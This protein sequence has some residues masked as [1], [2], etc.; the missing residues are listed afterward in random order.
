MSRIITSSTGCARGFMRWR[1]LFARPRAHD[2][3][4]RRSASSRATGK[5]RHGH[6]T[7]RGTGRRGHARWFGTAGN[8]C[9]GTVWLVRA[10]RVGAAAQGLAAVTGQGAVR[11]GWLRRVLRC[12]AHGR[13]ERVRRRRAKGQ[14]CGECGERIMVAEGTEKTL[15]VRAASLQVE[16]L[17][18]GGEHRKYRCLSSLRVL[19][20]PPLSSTVE[21]SWVG[22]NWPFVRIVFYRAFSR[23]GARA[24]DPAS[25]KA[26][27]AGGVAQN[28][29]V[30]CTGGIKGLA[31]RAA[32]RVEAGKMCR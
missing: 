6:E 16:D 7:D 12:A 22:R 10:R 32:G 4:L 21:R 30:V 28:N 9:G 26:P 5:G 1:I 27:Q 29:T 20:R 15:A 2:G 17:G 31:V 13:S 3:T 23:G 11:K 14:A 18:R 25:V 24:S 8:R 19:E